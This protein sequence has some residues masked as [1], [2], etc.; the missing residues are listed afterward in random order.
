MIAGVG[1]VIRKA[2]LQYKLC[3]NRKME[4]RW[5]E[6]DLVKNIVG[7]VRDGFWKRL[8]KLPIMPKYKSFIWRVCLDI[9][10]SCVALNERGMEV[11]EVCIWCRR[12]PEST[13]H[14]IVECNK[15]QEV[16]ERSRFDFGGRRYFES[17]LEWLNVEGEEWGQDQ[18]AS[19]LWDEFGCVEEFAAACNERQQEVRWEKPATPFC[20]L[21]TDVGTLPNEGG[22]LGGVVRDHHGVCLAA[23]TE[24]T[25]F[26]NEPVMLEVEAM[27]RGMEL[28]LEAGVKDLVIEGDAQLVFDTLFNLENVAMSPLSLTCICILNLSKKFS[29]FRFT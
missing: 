20:K 21:N 3:Y 8:W 18:W 1:V 4:L 10:P 12:E 25:K 7:C 5:K 15:V 23:F 24:Y 6:V 2:L 28:A 19:S 16:W 29:S 13:F 11:D 22:I 27:K 17:V 14:V 9:L 26:S